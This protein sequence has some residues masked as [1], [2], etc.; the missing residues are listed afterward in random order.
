MERKK[1]VE[2]I[3]LEVLG[4]LPEVDRETLQ[5]LKLTSDDFPWRELADYQHITALL[6]SV[7]EILTPAS[8]LK[9]KTALKLY[10]IRDEIKVKIDL[11]KS[12]EVAALPVEEKLVIEEK[13]E[14][15]EVIEVGEKIEVEEK[16][17][18]EA[19]AANQFS[20]IEPALTK[21]DSFKITSNFREKSEKDNIFQQTRDFVETAVTKHP[22][23]RE[24]IEKIIKDYINSHFVR[25][26]ES[27]KQSIKQSRLLSF[28]F[29]AITLILI[30]VIYFIK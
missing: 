4:C 17:A 16:M 18:V 14:F 28:I 10:N 13:E 23:D 15:G 12:L 24:M 30:G 5:S 27:L 8:D 6:P 9:D 11:K 22:P 26:L 21:D 3:K 1:I 7:L 19:V 2:L 25:D 29:F 20:G